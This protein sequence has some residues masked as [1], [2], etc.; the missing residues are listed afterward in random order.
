MIGSEEIESEDQVI[1]LGVLIDNKLIQS[2]DLVISYKKSE[3]N[4]M[5]F[6]CSIILQILSHRMALWKY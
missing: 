3:E 6:F 2:N 4:I 5:L 1:L